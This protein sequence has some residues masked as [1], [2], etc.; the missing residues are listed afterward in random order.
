MTSPA[1][2]ERDNFVY[3]ASGFKAKAP[4]ETVA[5]ARD[6]AKH[7]RALLTADT[8]R[9]KDQSLGYYRAQLI[10]YGLRPY[11]RKSDAKNQLL[12]AF[13]GKPTL[14][15]PADVLQV[16]AEMKAEWDAL[17]GAPET[18]PERDALESAAQ[19][20]ADK[21]AVVE[22]TRNSED[23]APQSSKRKPSPAVDDG[24][25]PPSKKNKTE[26]KVAR[27]LLVSSRSYP[28]TL[29]AQL[30][31]TDVAGKFKLS[32]S[33]LPG[34]LRESKLTTLGGDMSLHVAYS[35][36]GEHL[37]MDLQLGDVSATLRGPAPS[38]SGVCAFDW[39]GSTYSTE[40]ANDECCGTITFLGGGRLAGE[41]DGGPLKA[42]VAFE[43][44]QIETPKAQYIDSVMDWKKQYRSLDTTAYA[45]ASA[46]G[47]LL[48]FD[49]RDW[50]RERSDSEDEM[51]GPPVAYYDISDPE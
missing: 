36:T 51:E 19:T 20:D 39:R 12:R 29:A 34:P 1:P 14:P 33:N 25:E 7:L 27:F 28:L 40:Y 11:T 2:I 43:G 31:W 16:E 21:I 23:A 17:Q 3:D 8:R 38:V 48:D 44:T 26:Q 45:R 49:E 10:H 6:E 42:T 41:I 5:H 35:Q 30:A 32:S 22:E 24:T 4:G 46:A 18:A 13:S 37:W 50:Q 47:E 9:N 15:V